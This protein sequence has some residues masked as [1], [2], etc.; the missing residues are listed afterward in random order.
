M[1]ELAAK[2]DNLLSSDTASPNEKAA[3]I[4]SFAWSR[5]SEQWPDDS[6]TDLMALVV[7]DDF[8]VEVCLELL[9]TMQHISTYV[10]PS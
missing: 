1:L 10:V 3:F 2:A 4:Q 9:P 6:R 8:P 5:V 7:L